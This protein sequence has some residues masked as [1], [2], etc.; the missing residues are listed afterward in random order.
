MKILS[1][2]NI[3]RINGRTIKT[4]G[5]NF[6]PP[7]NFL[8][9]S[10]LDYIIEFI[11]AKM[12]GEPLYPNVWDKAAVYFYNIICNHIF[13]DGNKRTGLEA[14]LLFLSVNGYRLSK[15]LAHDDLLNF[16]IEVA[17]GQKTLEA[18][19]DWIK[20]NIETL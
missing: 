12:F 20:N 19:Q 17:S 8:H 15:S 9:E 4:H 6:V 2:E 18:C 10:N 1:K 14:M 11:D 5:G 7:N 3:V 13:S 16:V